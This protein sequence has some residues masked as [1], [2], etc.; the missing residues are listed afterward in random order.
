M[1]LNTLTP[2]K[3]WVENIQANVRCRTEFRFCF[4]QNLNLTF[5]DLPE[6]TGTGF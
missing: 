1:Q 5:H 2:R 6:A 3:C 4:G